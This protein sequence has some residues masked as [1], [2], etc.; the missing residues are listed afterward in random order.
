MHKSEK[1]VLDSVL[2]IS[3]SGVICL[4][5]TKIKSICVEISGFVCAGG[6]PCVNSESHSCFGTLVK[7]R[8]SFSPTVTGWRQS[9]LSDPD[10]VI[11]L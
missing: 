5:F 9:L 1:S 2:Y 6:S 10:C 11:M 3:C 8:N 7:V 4:A